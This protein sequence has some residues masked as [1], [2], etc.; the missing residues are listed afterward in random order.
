MTGE[1][2]ASLAAVLR[3]EP[4][5][6][7]VLAR[8]PAAFV[9]ACRDDDLTGLVYDVIRK[10]DRANDWVE[11]VRG[12]LAAEARAHAAEE[13]LRRRELMTVLAALTGAGIQ[14]IVIKGMALAYSVYAMPA[15]RRCR[16]TDLLVRRTELTAVRG[17]LARLGYAAAH[18]CEGELLFYQV[19]LKKTD[20]LGLVHTLDV[21]WKI[22]TQSLFAGLLTLDEIAAASTPLPALGIHARGA[23]PLHALLLACVHP[24]M[25]HRQALSLV[26]VYD[27]HLLA[28]GLS[29]SQFDQFAALARK[30]QAAAVC[31]HQLKLSARLMGTRIPDGLLEGLEAAGT[32]EPSAAYLRPDRRWRDELIWNLQGLSSWRERARLLREVTFPSARYILQAYRVASPAGRALLPALY[33]H[34]LTTGGWKVVT[35][36]K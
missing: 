4:L 36:R 29:A 25:H 12:A 17:T 20:S 13:L 11:S 7:T 10:Q 33:L 1:S 28:S 26:W 35:G 16:D 6:P 23:G 9:R 31:A 22:S 19:A 18:Q 5:P 24:V 15:A 2:A 8:D 27:V 32:S 14:P 21:H 34:R 3:D 30:K